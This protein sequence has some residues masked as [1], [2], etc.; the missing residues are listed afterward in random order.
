MKQVLP[1]IPAHINRMLEI[2]IDTSQV[3]RF[4]YIV[5]PTELNVYN[6]VVIFD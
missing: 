6:N 3:G 2:F 4:T 1:K 5:E